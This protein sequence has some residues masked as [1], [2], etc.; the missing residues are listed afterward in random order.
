MFIEYIN[1]PFVKLVR[2]KEN[3]K[4]KE[5]E[6]TASKKQIPFSRLEAA[7]QAEGCPVLADGKIDS[8]LS[9]TLAQSKRYHAMLA[10][11]VDNLTRNIAGDLSENTKKVSVPKLTAGNDAERKEYD[12]SGNSIN[13]LETQLNAIVA[14]I[15]PENMTVKM[16][17]TDVKALKQAATTEK[18]MQFS[19]SNEGRI[20]NKIFSAIEIRMNNKAYTLTSKAKAHKQDDRAPSEKKRA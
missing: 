2:V 10:Y 18:F 16:M 15:L 17:R 6:L 7:Y 8:D 9:K 20:L 5:H 12:F 3:A 14:T 13:A 1:N 4:T 11:F 19:M